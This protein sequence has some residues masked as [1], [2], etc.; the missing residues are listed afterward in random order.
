MRSYPNE[1][2]QTET[3]YVNK[4]KLFG[5]N[6]KIYLQQDKTGKFDPDN[7]REA[8]KLLKLKSDDA[9]IK[10]NHIAEICLEQG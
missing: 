4:C 5:F 2:R 8:V 3:Y 1:K 7:T 9:F 6:Y 10:L